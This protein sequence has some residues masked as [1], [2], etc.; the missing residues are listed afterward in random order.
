MLPAVDVVRNGSETRAR[1]S[2]PSV[3]GIM[4]S[5]NE[6]RR[7]SGCPWPVSP[8]FSTNRAKQLRPVSDQ[9]RISS[10]TLDSVKLK[11]CWAHEKNVQASGFRWGTSVR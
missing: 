1:G 3:V 4:R 8:S 7:S 11:R 6:S 2:Y 5:S 10:I 9:R